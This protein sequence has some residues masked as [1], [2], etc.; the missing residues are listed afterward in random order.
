MKKNSILLVLLSISY[1]FTY[2]QEEISL[3]SIVPPSPNAFHMTKYGEVPIN[4]STGV[5]NLNIPL[6]NF[7]ARSLSIPISA[8]Y[9]GN[10]VKTSQMPSIVGINWG[11]NAG[12]LITRIVRDEIDEYT[13]QKAYHSIEDLNQLSGKYDFQ[14]TSEWTSTLYNITNDV[15]LDSEAD[16]FNYNF[17]GYTGSFFLDENFQPHLIKYNKEIKIELFN[18]NK[19]FK[20]TT[21]EGV[22]YFFGGDGAT[23]ITRTRFGQGADVTDWVPTTFLLYQISSWNNE[24]IHFE[25]SKVDEIIFSTNQS[26]SMSRTYGLT[27]TAI[28]GEQQEPVYHNDFNFSTNISFTEYKDWKYILR[29]IYNNVN[30]DSLVFNTSFQNFSHRMDNISYYNSLGEIHKEIKFN[31]EQPITDNVPNKRFFLSEIINKNKYG[32]HSDDSYKFEYDR[33]SLLPNIDTYSVDHLGYFN[34]KTN[35]TLVPENVDNEIIPQSLLDNFKE[36]YG[37]QYFADREA[38]FDFAKIG[39]LTNIAYPT[40]GTT[41]FEYESGKDGYKRA[42]SNFALNIF[43]S[44]DNISINDCLLVEDTIT[45]SLTGTAVIELESTASDVIIGFCTGNLIV[46]DLTGNNIINSSIITIGNHPDPPPYTASSS[47]N[48]NLISGHSYLFR[49]EFDFTGV[50]TIAVDNYLTVNANIEYPQTGEP[51]DALGI[52]IKRIITKDN[53]DAIPQIKRYYYSS[54]ENL[55]DYNVHIVSPRYLRYDKYKLAFIPTQTENGAGGYIITENYLPVDM[56]TSD[57]LGLAFED[58]SNKKLYPVVTISYGG[59]NFENGGEELFFNVKSNIPPSTYYYG[60]TDEAINVDSDR[61]PFSSRNS[62]SSWENGTLYKKNIF[63]KIGDNFQIDQKME[64]FYKIDENK[65]VIVNNIIAENTFEPEVATILNPIK[66]IK[67]GNYIT[68]SKWY[69]LDYTIAKKY[70]YDI[71]NNSIDS[72]TT[73][74]TYYYEGGL[75]G[76]PSSIET[77]DSEGNII[78]TKMYYPGDVENVSSLPGS[79]LTSENLKAIDSLKYHHRINIPIQTDVT[80][81]GTLFRKRLIYND[82]IKKANSLEFITE[83]DTILSSKGTETLEERLVYHDYDSYGNP[84]EVSRADGTHIV[85]VWGYDHSKPIAKIE[86]TTYSTVLNFFN[87]TMFP[88]EES[89]TTTEQDLR[90]YFQTMRSA[91]TNSHITSYTYDPLIGVTSITDPRGE[92]VTYHYDDFNRLEFIKDSNGHIL[93]ENKYNYK[94]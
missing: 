44:N 8:N 62:N 71:D 77:T 29:K 94:N 2:S 86:N 26:M 35:T 9:S 13:I 92:T 30:S 28:L 37:E 39:S 27:Y 15:N 64:Y 68:F 65:S 91:F 34:G 33:L 16:I 82:W 6:F 83:L 58:D 25:Y 24:Q 54:K 17:N 79:S 19:K 76:I 50:Q 56:L 40:K 63:K 75:A 14:L 36:Y 3:P 55:N 4:E 23:E 72:L 51:K 43:Y 53:E 84:L 78:K 46:E 1:F 59:D 73:K 66:N 10:G 70:F 93:S 67:V 49:L 32:N 88:P 21:E 18:S 5:V 87:A 38:D 60:L 89:V 90:D 45:S 31:Y 52:R 12:G 85:Y 7:K 11:L 48:L 81:N 57:N 47:I 20:I 69:A 80:K 41:E 74:S 22:Q 61:F 42:S